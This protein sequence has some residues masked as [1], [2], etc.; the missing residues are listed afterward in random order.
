MESLG[1]CC[2]CC[3]GER[4][5][6]DSLSLPQ[7]FH[8]ASVSLQKGGSS[9]RYL[10]RTLHLSSLYGFIS[11]CIPAGLPSSVHMAICIMF[12]SSATTGWD[13]VVASAGCHG[14]VLWALSSP[15]ALWSGELLVA[16]LKMLV[17]LL[18]DLQNGVSFLVCGF[19][20]ML[21]ALLNSCNARGLHVS[22]E[23]ISLCN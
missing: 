22:G 17:S 8:W 2:F 5:A 15:A 1:C 14:G 19:G 21:L 4:K 12:P 18:V 9:D 6:P 11:H 13:L 10:T 7:T 3:S 16:L 23:R 20:R